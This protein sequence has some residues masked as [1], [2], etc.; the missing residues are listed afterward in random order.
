MTLSKL[1][2]KR[3]KQIGHHLKPCIIIGQHGI[4]DNL[5]NEVNRALD[6]H[7]LIKIKINSESRE[8]KQLLID[9]LSTK[10]DA[11]LVQ[12]I[13][14]TALLFRLAKKPKEKLSN[15]RNRNVS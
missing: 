13:G 11:E 4:G 15:I 3:Y 10:I 6:D 12:T 14:K 7:E 8:E 5:I 2:I 1:E 9:E